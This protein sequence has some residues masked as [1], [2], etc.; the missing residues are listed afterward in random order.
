M[1]KKNIA[2]LFG[3]QSSEHEVSLVSA[4]TII[5]NINKEK[6]NVIPIGIT[7]KGKW[8]TYD[9]DVENIKN[10]SWEKDGIPAV[11]SPDATQK[12]IIKI[13]EG[14]AEIIPVDIV[15]PVLHG[16]WG[17]DGTIQGLLELAQ[18]P[19]VGC[20]VLASAV[21]M[22]KYYTKIIA[23]DFGITQARYIYVFEEEMPQIDKILDFSEKNLGYPVFV[24]PANAGSSVGITKAKDRESLIKAIDLA[25]KHD[26]KVLIEEAIVGRELECAVLGDKENVI[27]SSVGE[28]IA[29]AEF[30]DYDAKYNNDDSRTIVNT[31]LPEGKKEELQ[32]LAKK[33]FKAVDGSGLA[34][35]DFFMEEGTNRIIFNEINTMPGFTPI[36]MYPML[37]ENSGIA[38]KDL[39]EKMIDIALNKKASVKFREEV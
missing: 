34:R 12:C 19:Y 28:I 15:F 4:S 22:D 16:A 23:E 30:Y 6:Y 31:E 39:I 29:G 36:S 8:L 24:K 17:E 2:V 1:D 9:G 27:A 18:I 3:G 25:L 35:V 21:S 14:K 32:E 11:I 33:V 38:I 10:G 37:M 5:S 26:R 7:K 13:N 20:G